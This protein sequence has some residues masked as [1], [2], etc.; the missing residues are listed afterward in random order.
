MCV[1]MHVCGRCA[2][3]TGIETVA[4][5]PDRLHCYATSA[6]HWLCDLGQVTLLI[7]LISS[8]VKWE[9]VVLHRSCEN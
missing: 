4:G 6:I 2:K 7:S 1:Y 3:V 8:S 5:C 9:E